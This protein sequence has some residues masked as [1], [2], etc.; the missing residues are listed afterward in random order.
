MLN[1][2][3]ITFFQIKLVELNKIFILS[4]I[5]SVPILVTA[6]SKVRVVFALSNTD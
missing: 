6:G 4:H 1:V 2:N 5:L 3:H